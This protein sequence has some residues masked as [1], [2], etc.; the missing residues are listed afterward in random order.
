MSIGVKMS[1]GVFG[2]GSIG[3]RHIHNLNILGQHAFWYD[4]A[5]PSGFISI[6]RSS[7]LKT[8]DAIVVA[9]P[10]KC[11]SEDLQEA[12]EAGKHVLVEKPFGY[13]CPPF[14]DGYL[15]GARKRYPHLIIATGFNLRFHHCVQKAK[16]IID[17]G[18]LGELIAASFVV[19]QKTEKEV[20]LRDGI[21]RNWLSHEIDLAHHLLGSGTVERCTAPLDANG[22]DTI[23]AFIEMKFPAVK[24][25]VFISGDYYTDP[26]Q[27]YF[28]IEGTKANLYV[29]LIRREIYIKHPGENP[30]ITYQAEDT[31]DQNYIDEMNSFITSIKTGKHQEPLATGEDGVRALYTVMDAYAMMNDA[32]QRPYR[33]DLSAFK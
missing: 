13:D 19:N 9:S 24:E 30:V 25:K 23:D 8:C 12:I 10:S 2:Y 15:M 11:H 16:E 33:P 14:L 6:P 22:K 26:E 4:P 27:R 31:F 32:G 21:I 3:Q 5:P 18:I 29:N 7:L 17:S 20:Y 1:I 28:W